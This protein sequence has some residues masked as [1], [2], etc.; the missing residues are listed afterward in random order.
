MLFEFKQFLSIPS[1]PCSLAQRVNPR[2]SRDVCG[3][4][5]TRLWSTSCLAAVLWTSSGLCDPAGSLRTSRPLCCRHACNSGSRSGLGHH[6]TLPPPRWGGCLPA[7]A[8]GS[9]VQRT[10]TD[11]DRGVR[12]DPAPV[13]RSR[14]RPRSHFHRTVKLQRLFPPLSP[15]C[16]SLRDMYLYFIQ[17]QLN[18]NIIQT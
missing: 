17:A 16:S 9:P 4:V 5:P 14:C 11:Q 3:M 2:W 15:Q 8:S 1:A 7:R 10:R 18:C 13:S 6:H 12:W